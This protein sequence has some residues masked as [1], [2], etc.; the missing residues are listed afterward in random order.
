MQTNESANLCS[1]VARKFLKHDRFSFGHNQHFV[2]D[3]V[4]PRGFAQTLERFFERLV[5][6]AKSAV[7]HRHESFSPEFRERLHTAIMSKCKPCK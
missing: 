7:V 1:S 4:N 6:E 3:A 2:F 5:T